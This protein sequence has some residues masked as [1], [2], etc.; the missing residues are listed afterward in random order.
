LIF[1]IN[2]RAARL[3]KKAELLQD[4]RATQSSKNITETKKEVFPDLKKILKCL[5][6]FLGYK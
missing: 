2:F 3:K 5:R 4:F 1:D 6:N